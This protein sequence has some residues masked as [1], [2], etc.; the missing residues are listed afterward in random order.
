MEFES[1]IAITKCR[2]I[3]CGD[4]IKMLFSNH[5]QANCPFCRTS[6]HRK[7]VNFT[8]YDR[9]NAKVEEIK[10]LQQKEVAVV[11]KLFKNK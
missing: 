2:H 4:C 9:L 3:M 11:M 5:S 8:H 1:E 7:D 6:I 10:I